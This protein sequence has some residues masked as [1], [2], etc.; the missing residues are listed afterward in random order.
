MQ[1]TLDRY[2]QIKQ[3]MLGQGGQ[4]VVKKADTGFNP[5]LASPVQSQGNGNIGFAGNAVNC[6]VARCCHGPSL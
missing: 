1:V 3:A 5:S 6:G 4:H 2:I